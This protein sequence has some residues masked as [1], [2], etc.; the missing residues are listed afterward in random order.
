M[1]SQ[2]VETFPSLSL[3]WIAKQDKTIPMPVLVVD[4]ST[5]YCGMY[6]RPRNEGVVIGEKTISARKG[7]IF[8]NPEKP[9]VAD[10]LAHEWRHHWQ[11]WSGPGLDPVAF[12]YGGEYRSAIVK[13]F[14]SSRCEYD[15]LRF[16]VKH[17]P[18]EMSLLWKSWVIEDEKRRPAGCNLT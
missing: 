9:D 18:S 3:S 2:F 10:T 13:Y 1:T 12:D 14:R 5:P 17:A 7:I 16:S 8:F 4:V 11:F 15:A 6:Y